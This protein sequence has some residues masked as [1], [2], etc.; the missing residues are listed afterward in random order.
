M[1]GRKAMRNFVGQWYHVKQ[2]QKF[3]TETLKKVFLEY[4]K[5]GFKK[6][7][8]A[9]FQRE[10]FHVCIKAA[11]AIS[12][13]WKTR[14]CKLMPNWTRN[15]MFTYT[16]FTPFIWQLEPVMFIFPGIVNIV[17]TAWS[18]IFEKFISAFP[19]LIKEQ[20][21]LVLSMG[22][23]MWIGTVKRFESWLFER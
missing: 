20:D 16:N 14:S 12:A 22:L 9:I 4:E 10:F 19:M 6:H 1:I 2:W 23:I 8:P 7:L 3:C 17:C 21:N 18:F 13:F 5:N 15:H 11:R